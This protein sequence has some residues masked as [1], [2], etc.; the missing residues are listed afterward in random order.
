MIVQVCVGSSCY[1][2]GSEKLVSLFQE[3]IAAHALT[4]EVILTG[5]FCAGKCNRTGVTVQVDDEI[6]PGVTAEGF[7]AFFEKEIL[8]RLGR[9]E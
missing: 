8:S 4:D 9:K 2:R 5:C 7:N 6:F 3:A 1:L